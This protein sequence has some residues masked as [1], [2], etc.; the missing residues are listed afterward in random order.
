MEVPFTF[1]DR[2]PA[3]IVIHEAET[4]GTAPGQAGSAGARVACITVPFRVE[5]VTVR[6]QTRARTQVAGP[7]HRS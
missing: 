1:T 7:A 2:A 3:S 4:T 6:A 5:P